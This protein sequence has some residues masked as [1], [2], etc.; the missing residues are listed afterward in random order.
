MGPITEPYKNNVVVK[1][2][3]KKAVRFTSYKDL[4]DELTSCL[5]GVAMMSSFL[6]R[7]VFTLKVLESLFWR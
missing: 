7:G 2:C 1:F 3:A 6:R 4:V 5:H